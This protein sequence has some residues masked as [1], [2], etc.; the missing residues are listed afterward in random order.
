M[1]HIRHH[2]QALM[3]ARDLA[4][5]ANCRHISA[6]RWK[7]GY[8]SHLHAQAGSWRICEEH[9]CARAPVLQHRRHSCNGAASPRS[10]NK[11]VHVVLALLQYLLSSAEVRSEVRLVLELVSKEAAMLFRRTSRSIDHMLCMLSHH[12]SQRPKVQASAKSLRTGAQP[13]DAFAHTAA[14]SS[15]SA[16]KQT[17]AARCVTFESQVTKSRCRCRQARSRTWM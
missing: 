10:A 11:G 5:Q 8:A 4:A 9:F 16:C 6:S 12:D 7:A 13:A 17:D 15:R 14:S 3:L 2:P 1:R